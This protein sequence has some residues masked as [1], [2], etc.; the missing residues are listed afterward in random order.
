VA[1]T[2][3]K[4]YAKAGPVGAGVTGSNY[5]GVHGIAKSKS[6]QY[7]TLIANEL[8]CSRLATA[9]LLPVPPGFLIK[10]S[11]GEVQFASL[12]FNLAGQSLPPA[13]AGLV[14]AQRPRLS[15]GIILFDMW[16]LNGDRHNG[17]IS[18]DVTTSAVQIFDH[19][20][21]LFAK[22][23]VQALAAVPAVGQPGN[24]CLAAQIATLDGMDEWHA[25]ILALPERYVRGVVLDVAGSDIGVDDA[26]AQAMANFLIDR[27]TQLVAI[28]RAHVGFFPKVP[29]AAWNGN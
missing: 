20:H 16:I 2:H 19:S 10:H 7:P 25:N 27:R 6:P 13:N 28:A 1:A 22:G 14:V 23:N 18:F 4:V 3:Y 17:N 12:D 29:A 26:T 9:L 11:D 15:W 21:A 5:V 8:V 24:H